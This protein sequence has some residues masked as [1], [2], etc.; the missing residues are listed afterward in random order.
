MSTV[1]YLVLDLDD[2]KDHHQNNGLLSKQGPD[3][4]THFLN[5]AK[6]ETEQ[7]SNENDLMI[8][9]DAPAD[10]PDEPAANVVERCNGGT[11]VKSA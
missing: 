8:I 10:V 1:I 5:E 3:T 2:R 7:S 9:P 4:S 11:V 6:I